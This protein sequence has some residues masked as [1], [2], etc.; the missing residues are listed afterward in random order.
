MAVRV[1]DAAVLAQLSKQEE[2]QRTL[3][4]A[5]EERDQQLHV[6]RAMSGLY[7]SMHLV[8]LV[9]DT[10]VEY[11]ADKLIQPYFGAAKGAVQTMRDIMMGV[12]APQYQ[13]AVLAFTDL[14]TLADRMQGLGHY[15]SEFKGLHVGWFI[16]NF[17]AIDVDPDGRPTTVLFTTQS[18]DAQ[19]KQEHSLFIRSS[20]M[21]RALSGLANEYEN[22]YSVNL[23][24]L[25][26]DILKQN[27]RITAMMK[28]SSRAPL[29]TELAD[30]Y[31]ESGVMPEYQDMMRDTFKPENVL[32]ALQEV[33]SFSKIYQNSLEQYCEVKVVKT[34]DHTA[35][36]GF[37]VK[38][39]VIRRERN[40]LELE[41]AK[42][43][44]EA[45]NDAK[46]SFLFNMSHDIRTPM[47]VIIGFR[48]LLEKHQEDPDKRAYYLHQIEES[49][50]ILLS[51]INNV[52]EMA[53]I[54]KGTIEVDEI[55]WSAE[56]FNDT[57]YSVFQGLMTEKGIDFTRHVDVQNHYVLCDPAKLRE[58]FLNILSNAYKYTPS[59]G[60]VHMELQEVPSNR[61]G[62]A[63]YRTTITDTGMGMS[64]EFLP[65]LFEE[66]SRENSMTVSKIE[67]T[68]LGMPIVKRLVEFMDGTIEVTSA[69]GK[70][71]SFAVT[72]PHKITDRSSLT[73]FDGI[74]IDPHMFEGKRILLAE[75]IA[76]NAEIA[77]AIL[78]E[79]GFEI[80]VAENGAVCVQMLEKAAQGYYDL[81]MMDVQMPIMNGY[82]ATRAIRKLEDNRKGSIPIIAM[83][84]N[85]FE[86]DKREALRC[87]MNGHVAKPINIKQLFRTLATVL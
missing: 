67:G 84:A 61:E 20:T 27:G 73:N 49:S 6:L 33:T 78:Q 74:E 77:C 17:T 5:L 4:A 8:D 11:S 52:L 19:K 37:A 18:I 36:I 87:G 35:I 55:A 9:H 71:T 62:W 51:I 3:T 60:K 30:A 56:Q 12:I 45:A 24:T 63:Y 13:D 10:V 14:T 48:D 53:R 69:L 72:L 80:E 66:F 22:V 86:E 41:Q 57:L 40:A 15:S 83:T 23:Q 26:T 31:V 34:G 16:A 29:Y 42:Q 43:A 64:E 65:H 85:A 1:T 46:T 7:F 25:E 47:N 59:G 32:A 2:H 79:A 82:D 44:A 68:G 76:V 39:D 38:D 50:T 54:E 21:E 28:E 75:D 81:I 70:G 58:V